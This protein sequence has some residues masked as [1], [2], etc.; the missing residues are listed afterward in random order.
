VHADDPAV[1]VLAVAPHP[2]DVEL[3]CGGTMLVLARA[4]LRTAVVDLTEGELSTNGTPSRRT[5]EREAASELLGL[6]SRVSL[7]LP[8][9]SL[10]SHASHRGALVRTLRELRPR[11]VL[12]PYPDHRHP[13]HAAA[14]P[15]VRDACFFAGVARHPPEGGAHRPARVYWYMLHHPFEP[16]LVVDVG[17]VWAERL[18]LLDVYESQVAETNG[19]VP[20]AVNDPGFRRL[21]EARATLYGSMAGVERGEP[22]R[23][24]GPLLLQL[25]PELAEP[26][27]RES[28]RYRAY[29]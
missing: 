2:D 14:G 1:D 24:E 13:D 19:A 4:G 25:L 3:F 9:G 18:E 5:A 17:E 29:L 22:F 11:V 26:A 10:G 21:I 27:S 16:S 20:T 15:L 6:A 8:D 23:V 7:G 12:A 28:S